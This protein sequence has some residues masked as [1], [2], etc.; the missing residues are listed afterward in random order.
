MRKFHRTAISLAVTQAVLLS[1]GVVHAQTEPATSGTPATPEGGQTVLVTGQRAALQTA[2]QIKQNAEEL[3]DS[4][5]AEEAGKLPDRSITEVLQR[6]VGVTVRRQRTIDND[7]KHFSEEDAGIKVRGLGWGESNLNGREIFSAGWPGKDLS[8]GAVPTELMAGVDVYKNPSAEHIEGAVSGITDLRTALPFDYKGTKAY[9]SVGT[10]YEETSKKFAPSLSGL[11]STQ[12]QSDFGRWGALIDVAANHSTSEST[13]LQ[14]NPYF[15]R[16][17]IVAGQTVWAP[18]GANWGVNK[19]ES[20]RRGFYGALQ[21]K[22][23]DMQSA[24]TYFTSGSRDQDT[25]SNMY[26]SMESAYKS[27]I[28]DPVV[29]GRGVVVSGHYR[30]P[31]GGLG[32][33][34]FAAGGIQMGTSRSF[35]DNKTR[36][37]ELAWNFKWAP[38]DRWAFQ[39]DVQWVNS[40]FETAGHELQLATYLPSM[41]ISTSGNDPV[42]LGFDQT[43]RD[44]LADP[45]NYYWNIIQPTRLKGDSNLYAWKTDAKFTFADSV[46]RDVR[47]GLRSSYRDSRR[48]RA[49]F[50]S[51]IN[52]GGWKSIAEPWNVRQTST[53]GQL[54]SLTDEP[55]WAGRGN[56]GYMSDPR[57]QYPTELFKFSDFNNGRTG[58]LPSVVFPTYALMK[59]YPNAYNDIMSNVRY[60]QC[61]DGVAAGYTTNECKKSDFAFDGTLVYGLNPNMVSNAGQFTHAVY[62]TLRFGFD[63]WPVPME[64][65]AGLRMVYTKSISKGFI[66]FNPTYGTTTPPDLPRFGPVN[67]P[68]NVS[69]T[70]VDALPSLNLKFDLLGNN[71]LL[72][73]LALSKGIYR[74][75]FKQMQES[76]SLSQNYDRNTNEVTY[77]GSNTGNVKLKPLSVNNFDLA[78]EWYPKDG[79][80]VTFAAFY[81]N[82]KD[83]IYDG[84][85]TRDFT[86]QGGNAQTFVI[87]GPRNSARGKVAGFE[88]T[89]DTYLDHFAALKDVLPDW[90]KGFGVSVNY[91]FLDSSQ[92]FYKDAQVQYCPSN[93]SITNDALKQYGCDTNGLP[94]G[95]LPL[96]G[97]TRNAANF[98]L[99]YDRGAFSARLAYNWNSRTLLGIDTG[100]NGSSADP[101]RPGARD[102]WWGLPKW[103]EAYGQ[104]DGGLNYS[105]TDKWSMSLSASNLNNVMVRETHQQHIGET[106]VTWR[107][108]GR[109]YYL[110]TRYE[111]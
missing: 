24:L 82:V 90:A 107:F 84:N 25:G 104:L 45:G 53:P 36:T 100:S 3:V 50:T 21:W 43:S 96:N 110:T 5:V 80:S 49:T 68:I 94:F 33:N 41:D 106:G 58:N 77:S 63:D 44:F 74:P 14:V 75:D 12:W 64:G 101:A 70:H 56:F 11:Y 62:S 85:Y 69:A 89:A 32:A 88:V 71:K 1:A 10:S 111:F 22:K 39:N 97:T 19:G 103:Q 34:N 37:S 109:S 31:T 81:K 7:A 51:D 2:Q 20:D 42:K 92:T 30:Y 65:N 8:W 95:K 29:D 48:E 59:D 15:A 102:T 17:D 35:N 99:R 40:N 16:T 78:L 54:P 6:V 91:S 72:G 4:V 76:I 47:F 79:Q 13:S 9:V 98:A 66:T 52:S 93:A 86:S 105:F 55:T 46:L 57:Y 38:S 87:S 18:T 83:I 23:N 26:T 67:E 73:R 108:P 60:Q 27:V 61:L 28:D